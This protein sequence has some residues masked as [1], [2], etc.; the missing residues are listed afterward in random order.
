MVYLWINKNNSSNEYEN[1]EC[2]LN[3]ASE[4]KKFELRKFSS[5]ISKLA[6]EENGNHLL[7]S[8][9]DGTVFLFKEQA[10]G[11]WDLISM[12]N[13]E[14]VMENVDGEGLETQEK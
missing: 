14:G 4:W 3:N 11:T 2:N 7:V 10:E 5:A 12:S 1:N 6:W 13:S 8:T 9:F